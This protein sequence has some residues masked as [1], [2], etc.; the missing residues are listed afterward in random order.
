MTIYVYR[1][2]STSVVSFFCVYF[3]RA[4]GLVSLTIWYVPGM[5]QCLRK[6]VRVPYILRKVTGQSRQFCVVVYELNAGRPHFLCEI[7]QCKRYDCLTAGKR[8]L[9]TIHSRVEDWLVGCWLVGPHVHTNVG[10][11]A[12]HYLS[13][14]QAISAVVGDNSSKTKT[15][16][17][18]ATT[19]TTTTT[20]TTRYVAIERVAQGGVGGLFHVTLTPMRWLRWGRLY[21]GGCKSR[22]GR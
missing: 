15:T 20:T 21:S 22:R 16:T 10:F 12:E 7:P 8:S 14:T 19:T 2:V 18:T 9:S 3:S 5:Q 1:K 13:A 11:E 17:A 4:C 6:V